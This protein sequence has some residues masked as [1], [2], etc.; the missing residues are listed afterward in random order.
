LAALLG[1]ALLPGPCRADFVVLAG[2]DP[3]PDQEN[4]LLNDDQVGTTISGFTNTTNREVTFTSAQFLAAPSN[5]QA[6]VEARESNDINSPQLAIDSAIAVALADPGLGFDSLVFN[7][8]IGGG[9][10]EDGTLSIE[11][12]GVD[13]GNNPISEL[14]TTDDQG[15]PLTLGNGSNFYT[16]VASAGQRITS[17]VI[18]PTQGSYADLRQVRLGGIRPIPEPASIALVGMGLAG[19][20]AVARRR[21]RDPVG[22]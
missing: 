21:R 12:F 8:F 17:V 5:G 19:M 16:I 10:G 22:A 7:A 13:A 18:T 9:L 20:L 4:I 11:V 1:L 6:R 14:F 15:D 3:Q 2:N